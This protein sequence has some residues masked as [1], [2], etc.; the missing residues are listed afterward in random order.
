MKVLFVGDTHANIGW[1]DNVVSAVARQV[2]AEAVVQVGDFGFEPGPVGGAFRAAVSRTGVPVYFLDGN[3][4][5]HDYLDAVVADARIAEG[6]TDSSAP[7]PVGDGLWYLP[8]GGRV[9]FGPVQ[10]CALGGA[11]S[12]DRAYRRPGFSW[13]EQET[14]SDA[15]IAVAVAGGVADV[16]LCHDAPSGWP[17]PGLPAPATMS[18]AFQAE[19]PACG[20]HRIRLREPYEAVRPAIVIHGHY[21]SRYRTVVPEPW[22][23]VTVEG[24]DCDGTPGAFTVIDCVNPPKLTNVTIDL[25]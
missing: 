9:Q 1:W 16:L 11:H 19:L 5:H 7:V 14:V 17:I 18:D 15:D 22:G 20:E 25:E 12:I 13:F 8:R 2:G 24:L 23:D 21:H 3:H 4:E 10:F 6:I